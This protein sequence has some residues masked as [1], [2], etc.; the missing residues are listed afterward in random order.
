[1]L[2]RRQGKSAGDQLFCNDFNGLP[3]VSA[4]TARF[5]WSLSAALGVKDFFDF[6][7]CVQSSM[8][9]QRKTV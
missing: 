3:M 4:K 7:F 2:K 9:V 8:R 1:M 6:F 5:D